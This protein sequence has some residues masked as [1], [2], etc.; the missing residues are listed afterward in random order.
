LTAEIELS[1][2]HSGTEATLRHHPER[3]ISSRKFPIVFEPLR[4]N[5]RIN[6]TATA[7]PTEAL[8]KFW[9]T[10]TPICERY[11]TVVSPEY[12]CQFVFVTNETAVFH[13]SAGVTPGRCCRLNGRVSL[14]PEEQVANQDR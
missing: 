8:R 14:Q 10:S 4:E 2:T 9:T 1:N 5:P 3:V 7:M 13:A 6:V 12:A 11:D